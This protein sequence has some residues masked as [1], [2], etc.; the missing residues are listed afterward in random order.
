MPSY[1]DNLQKVTFNTAKR[2]FGYQASWT[3]VGSQD[4]AWEGI[5]L[6]QNPTEKYTGMGLPVET[7]RFQMEYQDGD[8][9]GLKEIVDAHESYELEVVVIDGKPYRVNSIEAVHD[10]LTFRAE[11][12]PAPDYDIQVVEE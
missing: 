3:P 8:L 4:V 6:F 12:S 5:V 11:I 9:P 1:F 10:G 7:E 2:Q